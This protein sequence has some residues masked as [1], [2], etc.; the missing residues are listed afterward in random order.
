MQ[1][2]VSDELK[3]GIDRGRCRK[4]EK[5]KNPVAGGKYFYLLGVTAFTRIDLVLNCRTSL[6]LTVIDRT[7]KLSQTNSVSYASNHMT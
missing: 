1:I 5:I 4:K 7:V 3:R 2:G 6:R